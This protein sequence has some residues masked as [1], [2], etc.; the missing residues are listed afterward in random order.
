[1]RIFLR[2]LQSFMTLGPDIQAAM[3]L[4]NK[5]YKIVVNLVRLFKGLNFEICTQSRFFF[6]ESGRTT[7]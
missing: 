4:V 1:L 3:I 2:I 5:R 6:Q 7:I